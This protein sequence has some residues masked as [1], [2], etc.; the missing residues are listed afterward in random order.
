M[1]TRLLP[2][3]PVISH[4]L[5]ISLVGKTRYVISTVGVVVRRLIVILAMISRRLRRLRGTLIALGRPRNPGVGIGTAKLVR[6]TLVTRAGLAMIQTPA[7]R[8]RIKVMRVRVGLAL[9]GM[10]PRGAPDVAGARRRAC[11]GRL[12]IL[13]V[14]KR[15]SGFIAAGTAE[16]VIVKTKLV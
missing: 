8:C 7:I 5:A 6:V 11:E 10:D 1:G 2:L 9:Q 13:R 15:R 12:A 4:V 3:P 16:D 14:P